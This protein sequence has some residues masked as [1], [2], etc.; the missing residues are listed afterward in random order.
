M[1]HNIY[2][3]LG[4]LVAGACAQSPALAQQNENPNLRN[5]YMGRQ[6]WDIIPNAPIV[7]D[8]SGAP[9]GPAGGG[10][11]GSM[12]QRQTGLP[13]AGWNSYAPA[14]TPPGLSTSLPKVNNGVPKA[15]VPTGTGHRAKPGALINAN[16]KPAPAGPHVDPNALKA[17]K[18]YSTYSN[19][20]AA[21][22]AVGDG[23]KASAKVHGNVVDNQPPRNSALHWSRGR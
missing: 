15:P 13:Q 8:R 2:I 22:S 23:T 16:K 11:Q 5:F 20:D 6:Q 10:M 1:K 18:P 19:P 4:I 14:G 17:Y 21:A 7:N 9:A 3:W 12:P